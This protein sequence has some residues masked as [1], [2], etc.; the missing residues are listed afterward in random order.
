MEILLWIVIAFLFSW[1]V[2]SVWYR[3]KISEREKSLERFI[4]SD[5]NLRQML[6]NQDNSADNE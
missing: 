5:E 3:R 4:L 2:I 1:L 6:L